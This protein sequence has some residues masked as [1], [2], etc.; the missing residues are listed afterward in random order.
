MANYTAHY[1]LHQWEPEDSF[2]R[3]D[4]NEDNKKV[5]SALK[6]LTDTINTK[7]SQLSATLT[8]R[9]SELNHARRTDLL[10]DQTLESDASTVSLSLTG[11]NLREYYRLDLVVHAMAAGIYPHIY[12]RF[13]GRSDD[14]YYPLPVTSNGTSY[15]QNSAE[16]L[17]NASYGGTAF[18]SIWGEG[19]DQ[20]EI[21][22]SLWGSYPGNQSHFCA[23]GGRYTQLGYPQL[24]SLDFC[25]REDSN[26]GAVIK[27]GT[28]FRLYGLR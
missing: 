26:P 20:K 21:I 23:E 15:R 12:M 27:A 11:I 25:L 5:D 19:I 13:N 1:Q 17:S 18:C 14:F 16:L 9:V 2:L 8:G 22:W 3:T 6:E 28:R 7:T 4:F 24:T 10:L